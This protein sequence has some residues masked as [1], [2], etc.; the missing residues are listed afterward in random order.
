MLLPEIDHLI[1]HELE[2]QA[3][4]DICVSN[5]SFYKVCKKDKILNNRLTA[6]FLTNQMLES[7]AVTI[8]NLPYYDKLPSVTIFKEPGFGM[9]FYS[10]NKQFYISYGNFSIKQD[11]LDQIIIEHLYYYPNIRVNFF[12]HIL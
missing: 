11:E 10:Q 3:L 12:K 5:K 8:L 9:R 1:L 4:Y 6:R 7:P 2:G